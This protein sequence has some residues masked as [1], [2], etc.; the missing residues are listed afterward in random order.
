MIQRKNT[1]Q[2]ANEVAEEAVDIDL[3]KRYGTSIEEYMTRGHAKEIRKKI[4]S[5]RQ[6]FQS[7]DKDKDSLITKDE[8]RDFFNKKNVNILYNLY[9]IA[10]WRNI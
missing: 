2:A 6:E 7:I 3:K 4:N 9:K 1:L 5:L 10:K 8:L